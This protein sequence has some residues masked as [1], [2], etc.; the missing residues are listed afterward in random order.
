MQG[1]IPALNQFKIFANSTKTLQNVQEYNT[2]CPLSYVHSFTNHAS[3]HYHHSLSH[4]AEHPISPLQVSAG[5][6]N[7][8]TA[9][10]EGSCAHTTTFS[11]APNRKE[12]FINNPNNFLQLYPIFTNRSAE[13]ATQ[14][15]HTNSFPKTNTSSQFQTPQPSIIITS[16][17]FKPSA[18]LILI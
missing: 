3:I 8:E 17:Q 2:V 11:P 9:T 1:R 10:P 5:T 15:K 6:D 14:C 13:T 4:P 18:I 7:S 16:A 12:M